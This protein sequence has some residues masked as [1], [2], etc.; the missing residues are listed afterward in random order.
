M[1]LS[2]REKTC[3]LVMLGNPQYIWVNSEIKLLLSHALTCNRMNLGT[4]F[5]KY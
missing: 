4:V 1:V 3:I 2:P 5:I